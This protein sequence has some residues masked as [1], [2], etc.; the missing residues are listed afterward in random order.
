[1]V[2]PSVLIPGVLSNGG[3]IGQPGLNGRLQ[4]ST[5]LRQPQIRPEME[6]ST[7]NNHQNEKPIEQHAHL[8]GGL[9]N[10]FIQNSTGNPKIL[11][12]NTDANKGTNFYIY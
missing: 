11:P 2:Q 6:N 8:Y 1:M 12:N 9:H 5:V 7:H 4:H 3:I 10:G